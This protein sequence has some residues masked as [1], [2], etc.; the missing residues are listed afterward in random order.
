MSIQS[1]NCI[2]M[3]QDDYPYKH[4]RAINIGAFYTPFAEFSMVH[5]AFFKLC[6]SMENTHISKYNSTSRCVL[7]RCVEWY[8]GCP[9]KFLQH[10]GATKGLKMR[11]N[12]LKIPK[13]EKNY[14]PIII[15]ASNWARNTS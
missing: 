12:L 10:M 7:S 2:L 9:C 3:T 13:N 4:A 11:L 5:S 14:E 6:S 1:A 15:Q 8:M